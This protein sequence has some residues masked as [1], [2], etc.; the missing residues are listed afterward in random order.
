MENTE[1][2]KSFEHSRLT[3]RTNQIRLLTLHPEDDDQ[4]PVHCTIAHVDIASEPTYRALSYTWG[5]PS[6]T[7][8]ISING[9]AYSVRANLHNFLQTWRRDEDLCKEYLW[10][11]QIC[12]DQSND[13][14]R[15]E[16]VSKMD[17]V[18]T[19]AKSVVIW[20]G[21]AYPGCD[22]VLENILVADDP[23][24]VEGLDVW[25]HNPVP[26]Q[27]FFE[28]PYWC[29]LWV[30][31]EILLARELLVC[32]GPHMRRWNVG[33]RTYRRVSRLPLKS[34]GAFATG[35]AAWRGMDRFRLLVGYTGADIG[36]GKGWF[37]W[38]DAYVLAKGSL[39]LDTRDMIYG[40]MGIV[41]AEVRFLPDYN[42]SLEDL[43]KKVIKMHF[44][45][46]P[47][48]TMPD[49]HM[50]GLWK[51]LGLHEND[52]EG[53]KFCQVREGCQSRFPGCTWTGCTW[54]A[55]ALLRFTT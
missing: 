50:V 23:S 46:N 53:D 22:V 28:L 29:R 12:I 17:V 35:T 52:L 18:Y 43:Y 9:L 2:H 41:K 3:S 10:I 24:T 54:R 36:R 16:Q 49:A 32:L 34:F 39:C 31:Q 7:F 14:E 19:Q 33:S 11:D 25:K 42:I 4:H 13:E 21:P 1:Q 51:I 44:T 55:E 38:V 37:G 26:W 15:C 40:M 48:D 8:D 47:K 5:D 27:T 30:C 20:L 45:A 6:P